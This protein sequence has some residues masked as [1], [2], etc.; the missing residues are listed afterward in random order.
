MKYDYVETLNY[1]IYNGDTIIIR[2]HFNENIDQI[3]FNNKISSIIFSKY[4][5][6]DLSI[7]KYK[8]PEFIFYDNLV[9]SSFNQHI[10]NLPSGILHIILGCEFNQFVDKLP[11]NLLSL[12]FGDN[13]DKPID[14][15][16]QRLLR[17]E[18][19]CVFNQ[20]VDN[21]P[22][23]L[24]S[25]VFGELFNKPVDNLPS[26]LQ[27][28]TFGEEFNQTLD[29]LPNGL[30]SIKIFDIDLFPSYDLD[31][32]CLPNSVCE[33]TLPFYY[34]KEI[35]KLPLNLKKIFC[36]E[37]YKYIDELKLKN[38]NIEFIK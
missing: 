27:Y 21:L 4:N 20:F 26:N 32:N 22:S 12:T 15:L 34:S 10:D 18:L 16:P 5:T 30:I 13:F 24:Q 2:P 1:W 37:F 35:K 23:N 31:I 17:L 9:G 6:A 28:L 19:G 33:I 38:I 36:S 11:S 7:I 8:D 25:I 29:N 14:N 3:E